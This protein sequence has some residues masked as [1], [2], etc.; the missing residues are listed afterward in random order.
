[1]SMKCCSTLIVMFVLPLQPLAKPAQ[2]GE[3]GNGA[4]PYSDLIVFGD[5][6]SDMGNAAQATF[7]LQ[8]GPIYFEGRFS[9]GRV[10]AELLSDQLDLETLTPSASGGGN[11]AFGGARTSGT[12]GLAGLFIEDIDEQVDEFLAD[13]SV[14]PQALLV[15][16]AGANDLLNDQTDISTPV[17]NLM[18]DLQRLIAADGRQFLVLNLPPLGS[19]PRFN[20][21]PAQAAAMNEITM[22]FNAA[23]WAGLDELETAETD[24][25]IFRLDVAGLFQDVLTDPETFGFVNVTDPAAP[26]LEP[27]DASY[28]TSLIVSDPNSYLFWDE[29]H[30]TA[31]AH[32]FLAQRAYSV[33][34]PEP[35]GMLLAALAMLTIARRSHE[36]KPKT[37]PRMDTLTRTS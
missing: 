5:T 17:D 32:A 31:A 23:L 30:P 10:Y 18:T 28:D 24:V 1:M 15:V 25:E 27:G 33:V 22:Q 35:S 16:F 4:E 7:G 21:D 8:P 13:G 36:N 14:D 26:G 12:G 2:S 34:V 20:A 19:A 11:F 29:L 6:L 37:H 9:N 3:L